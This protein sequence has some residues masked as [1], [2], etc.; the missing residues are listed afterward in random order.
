VPTSV[1]LAVLAAAGLLALAPALTR[2]REAAGSPAAERATSMARVLPRRRRRR[3]VPG[4]RPVNPPSFV[5]VRGFAARPVRRPG[6]VADPRRVRAGA[7]RRRARVRPARRRRA[8]TALHRRRRVLLALLL[9]NLVELVGALLVGPG[10][11][12]GFG[13]SFVTLLAYLA[14][15]RNRAVLARRRRTARRRKLAWIAAEQA[16]VRRQQARRAAQRRAAVRQAA[17]EREAAGRRPAAEYVQR[18][19]RP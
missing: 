13:V 9:L 1:L 17:A 14:Y 15:L 12:I 18:Y 7:R 2:H 6:A 5:P 10:F 19:A 4:R 8:P 3:T 11:W 16:A